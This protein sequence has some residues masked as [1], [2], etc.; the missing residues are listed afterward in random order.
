MATINSNN[1]NSPAPWAGSQRPQTLRDDSSINN[2]SNWSDFKTAL[3]NMFRLVVQP[4]STLGEA[5]ADKYPWTWFGKLFN[6]DY[7]GMWNSIRDDASDAL[8]KFP[9]WFDRLSGNEIEYER[10]KE[11]MR[12]EQQWNSEEAQVARR[13]A[14]GLNPFMDGVG[15]STASAPS[16]PS[17]AGFP[18]DPLDLASSLF[19]GI[20]AIPQELRDT[21]F[22]REKVRGLR[23]DNLEKAEN[24]GTNSSLIKQQLRKLMQDNDF[25]EES[26]E[27]ERKRWQEEE[28]DWS[29]RAEEHDK[30]MRSRDDEHTKHLNDTETYQYNLTRRSTQEVLDSLLIRSRELSNNQ[31]EFQNNVMNDLQKAYLVAQTNHL[32]NMDDLSRKQYNLDLRKQD[33]VEDSFGKDFDL[34]QRQFVVHAVSE[35]QRLRIGEMQI[36]LMDGKI[37]EQDYINQLNRMGVRITDDAATRNAAAKGNGTQAMF[38]QFGHEF[39]TAMLGKLNL[40]FGVSK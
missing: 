31:L 3:R 39:S 2:P 8:D 26:R 37:T 1:G 32:I 36:K 15:A 12:M 9:E 4:V 25:S 14:A 10:N 16:A 34:K 20:S 21:A 17:S 30:N 11:L 22:N 40:L 29:R 33:F 6:R 19:S 38:N 5:Y 18:V 27:Q 28:R 24:M 35:K 23:L 7:Q 13:L